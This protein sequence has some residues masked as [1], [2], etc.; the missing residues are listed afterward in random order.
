MPSIPGRVTPEKKTKFLGQ[1]PE[2]LI[3]LDLKGIQVFLP[4]R[5]PY[6]TQNK[7]KLD[8]KAQQRMI[9]NTTKTRQ[10]RSIKRPPLR[11]GGAVER[12]V[13]NPRYIPVS[14]GSSVAKYVGSSSLCL[15]PFF[16][17]RRQNAKTTRG[18]GF[19]LYANPT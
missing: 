3:N 13:R 9:R 2:S 8:E 6:P 12:A 19:R 15:I 1:K 11:I 10:Q 14:P 16:Y 5:S 4:S 7:H 18:C 17:R